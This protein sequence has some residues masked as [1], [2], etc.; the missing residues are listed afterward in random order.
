MEA[1][2]AEA[3][4]SALRDLLVPTI[5]VTTSDLGR[6]VETP[7]VHLI[8]AQM[9]ITGALFLALKFIP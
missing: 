5:E 9:L 6:A 8:A 2:Q 1:R 4:A 7:K 3:L